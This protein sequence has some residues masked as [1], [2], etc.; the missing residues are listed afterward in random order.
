MR[1]LMTTTVVPLAVVSLMVLVGASSAFA[2][3]P[4]WNVTSTPRPATL[5]PGGDG[6]IVVEASNIG[7][8]TTSGPIT[9]TD[10]LPEGVT[11]QKVSPRGVLEPQVSF[12]RSVDHQLGALEERRF[13]GGGLGPAEEQG[14]FH[15]CSEPAPREVRCTIEEFYPGF[16]ANLPPYVLLEL[17]IAVQVQAGAA[18]GAGQST[19]EVS[20]GGAPIAR[21]KRAI[22]VGEAAPSFGLEEFTFVPESEGGGVDS[23][24]G[25]HP[26]QLTTTTALNQNTDVLT[27]PALARSFTDRLPV[28]FVGNTTVIPQ[29][30]EADFETYLGTYPNPDICPADTVVGVVELTLDI[31]GL[32]GGEQTVPV[33]LFNL[34]PAVGEP[35]RFGFELYET[36]VTIDTSVRTG[37]DYGVTAT[38]SNTTELVNF[39]AATITFWGVPGAAAHHASRGWSCL[40]GEAFRSNEPCGAGS[41]VKPPPFLTL[42]TSCAAPWTA[43]AEGSSWPFR[44]KPGAQP[45]SAPL[46]PLTYSLADAAGAAVGLTGC[47]RLPFHPFI[48]ASPDAQEASKPSGL[49]VH[50]RV[51]QED[52]E[53]AGG[54]GSSNVKDITVALPAGVDINPAGAGG[55]EACG[56]GQVGFEA[57]L[58]VGGFEELE[59]SSEPGV[60]TPLFTATLPEPLSPGLEL[61]AKGFCPNA[62]K[63]GTAK[64]TS[65]DIANPVVG[66]VYLASQESNPFGSVVAMYLVAEDP[67]SGTIVKLPGKVALCQNTGETIAGL[68]CEALGQ[69]I[70]TFE[71]EPQ[72]P[73]EDAELHF[74][75]GE[76]A[77]LSTP[78]R[79]GTYTTRASF[80][81]WSGNEP[82]SSTSSFQITS[83]PNGG[84][85]PGTPLP[86]SPSV[87]GGATNIQAGAFSPLTV[88][89]SRKDGEQNLKSIVAK[90]P[91]GLSG[92]LTG[93]ELCPEP[94]ASNGTCGPNSLIGEAT[95]SVGVGGDPFTVSG[96]KF[97]L[98]GPYEGAPFGLTFEVPAKAGPFD[99]AK[100]Q[101]NHPPCDCVIVRGKIEINPLTTALTITSNPPGSPDS[102]PTSIE[103]IPL[104]IQH[105]NA[106]TTRGSFQFNPTNC[107]KM[108]LEGTVLLS[109]GGSDTLTT[110]F[111]VTNCAALKFAP[112]FSVS[113]GAHTSKANGASLTAKLSEPNEP[114]GSQANI[115]KVKVE[116]PKQLPSRLTTL[117]KACTNAQFEANPAGCPAESKIGHAKVTTPLLPVPLEGPAIFVSHGGEA[118]PS[119]TMVLQGYGV[120]VDLVGTTFIS[121]AGVTSTTFKAVPDVP[122][123]TFELTLPTGRFSALTANGNLCTQKLT[124]PTEFVAQNGMVL[125]Q[126]TKVAATGCPKKKALTRAQKLA[127][128]LK[129]CH[130]RH[131]H[132]KRAACE[133][134]ARRRY[135]PIAKKKRK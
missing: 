134:A 31:P 43:T 57:G 118:F 22:P 32:G 38:V 18:L 33:P 112:K 15:A 41:A 72:L 86:F 50:V 28:G 91:P 67:V 63:I 53:N 24:A 2:Q 133:R 131:N 7:D 58:G 76:R 98:T 128:A 71:N 101:H 34:V 36:P 44:A 82:V 68:A 20:G 93:V 42:P 19:V 11:V 109:E 1:R 73:F 39:Q 121:K 40:A 62:S 8:A 102:I 75:G 5:A 47:D 130:K 64:I 124:M 111:Q 92:I 26:F 105:V 104:E 56:E 129:A 4:W 79:C 9:I 126:S 48:E 99:L 10:T 114:F 107:S 59:P 106:T 45:A 30:S 16:D 51:P 127:L 65:P 123:N 49:T 96:G 66:S 100:T 94:Q 84:P 125:N 25:S 17:G 87:T 77:P 108:T 120:T 117:Q 132:A 97:Y 54:L 88:S 122:F 61:G 6:V 52:N 80:A 103:G 74:F 29:C 135:A 78:S 35:A 14:S 89:V 27:P 37:G 95:V 90:L 23:Q 21:V 83:G 55:L 3:S 81:P 119:L 85:C 70:T 113:T 13:K 46:S 116:L 110:P 115:S 69:I 12:L 60:K